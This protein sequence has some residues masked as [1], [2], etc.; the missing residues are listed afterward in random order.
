MTIKDRVVVLSV[1]GCRLTEIADGIGISKQ[2]VHQNLTDSPARRPGKPGR[3]PA[4]LD[5]IRP[6]F[7]PR[8]YFKAEQ[9]PR[10]MDM[11]RSRDSWTW[12]EA[13]RELRKHNLKPAANRINVFLRDLGFLWAKP[14]RPPASS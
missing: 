2:R 12:V 3:P 10:V 1:Q 9:I 13:E 8:Q 6:Q 4:P 7:Q 14:K 11:H 5:H